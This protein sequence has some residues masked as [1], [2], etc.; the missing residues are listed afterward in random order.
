MNISSTSQYMLKY[1]KAKAK[2]VEYGVDKNDY[3]K[4]RLNSDEL[5]YPTIYIISR[6]VESIIEDN[7]EDRS[8]F[9][10][11]LITASQYFDAAV[12]SKDREMH[13]ADFLLSGTTAYFLSNDFGSAKVLCSKIVFDGKHED[14]TPQML[15]ITLFDFILRNKRISRIDSNSLFSILSNALG[16]FFLTGKIA[17]NFRD[18]LLQYRQIIYTN[19]NPIDIFYVDILIAVALESIK[20][21]A[22]LLLPEYTNIKKEEWRDYLQRPN[23]TKILWPS[24]QLIGEKGVLSG[25]SAIVQLPTGVGKTKSIELII[26]SAFLSNRATTVIIVAPLRALCNEITGDMNKVFANEAMVNSFSDVLQEDFSLNF[27]T[28]FR[29]RI[30]ICT[31]EK[32]NYIMHHQDGI[33][34]DIDLFIFDEGHMFDDGSRGALYELLISEIRDN[35]STDRQFVLLSAVLSNAEQIKEWLFRNS[36]VLA[37][38]EKIKATPKSIG[39]ASH[40]K[41][42]N[43][44]SDDAAESDY[45]IPKSI[46]TIQLIKLKGERAIRFFPVMTDAKDIAIYYA[47]KLCQN[48][49]VA[50]YVNRTASVLTVIKRILELNSRAYSLRGLASVTNSEQAEKIRN[51]IKAYY[52][53]EYEFSQAALLGVFPHYADLPN[54]IKVSIE[55]AVRH[56]HIRF[57]VCTSTLAQ[58]V[59]IPI[60]YLFMTSFRLSKNSMQIRS[61]QN[62]I[63]RT[64]RSGMYTEG[65]V[66]VTDPKFYDQRTDRQH[67]GNYRWNDCIKMFDP[68][69]SEPCSSSILSVVRDINIDH[70][71]TL[72]GST[73]VGYIIENYEQT[74]CFHTLVEKLVSWF[75][76]K[77]PQKDQKLIISAILL[78]KS[79]IESIEN[80]LC[81]VF[82]SNE[83]TDYEEC[84]T[85]M[86]CNTLA[87]SL[88]TDKEKE[89]LIKLF[90]VIARKIHSYGDPASIQKYSRT[91]IGIDFARRIEEWIDI[92]G[93]TNTLYTEE[94]LLDMI[95]Y[96][97]IETHNIKIPSELFATLCKLWIS[98]KTFYEMSQE[99]N[100]QLNISSIEDVCSKSIS[101]DLSFFVGNIIDML[102]IKTDD[103]DAVNPY[104]L[105]CTLQK[106]IKYGVSSVTAIV[107]CDTVFN[108]RFLANKFAEILG[109][110]ISESEIIDEIKYKRDEIN[111]L[112]T[113]F[114]EFFSEKIKILFTS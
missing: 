41:D 85:E 1:Q 77:Y 98:E 48:G 51:L 35:I 78:R 59:N 2:L 19:D 18:L 101:Y 13:D 68:N 76:D 46:N 7:D 4:F 43:Y 31:P 89:Y 11:H 79:I 80:H 45:Y 91:M 57:V 88:A 72:N 27:L 109:S 20:K 106:K 36:G 24:Q 47:I 8:E 25:N 32:L 83:L 16:V 15:L 52:G 100:P 12:N 87:Y 60:K 5:S 110:D 53:E 112:L 75:Q 65:S 26:R 114:P 56:N 61:F 113:P 107:V 42:I 50:I 38:S 93:I 54:G 99:R 21:S 6:Y 37:S 96:F 97:F 105:L 34:S 10:P 86:C 92:K 28:L 9:S 67:G 71:V 22:W 102:S 82:S 103:E 111:A 63:G 40:T 3:P 55:Y 39:F 64:A 33:L 108:D 14:E 23:A 49:G 74:T 90:S 69:A 104:F 30:I 66:V 17:E 94:Q 44:F 81:F 58:G 95:I 73:I 62:L 70:E 84:A 29:K